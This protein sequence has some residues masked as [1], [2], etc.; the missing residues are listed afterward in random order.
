M[1]ACFYVNRDLLTW[2]LNEDNIKGMNLN[3]KDIVNINIFNYFPKIK[4]IV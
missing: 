3:L 2:M 1:K 4:I